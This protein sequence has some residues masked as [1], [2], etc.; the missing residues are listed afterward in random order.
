[1]RIQ[2][3]NEFLG[4]VGH[5]FSYTDFF[6]NKV[7]HQDA[8]FKKISSGLT[9]IAMEE[10]SVSEKDFSR[11][12]EIMKIVDSLIAETPEVLERFEYMLS[13]G[14]REEYATEILWDEFKNYFLT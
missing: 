12:D 8:I 6:G 7:S 5:D 3:I 14:K 13:I 10:K 4:P 1:M 9:R 11:I 2:R